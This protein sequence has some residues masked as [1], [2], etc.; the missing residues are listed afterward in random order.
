MY[1]QF[2]GRPPKYQNIMNRLPARDK[3]TRERIPVQAR[4]VW[5]YDGEQWKGGHALR[6]DPDGP[7][8]YVEFLDKRNKF[9]GAWLHPDDVD[10]DNKPRR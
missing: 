6:L 1:E 5:E 9:T 7:A 8:I 3:P 2:T 4:I 10:W